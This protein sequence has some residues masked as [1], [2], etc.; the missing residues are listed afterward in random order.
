MFE[1][2]FLRMLVLLNGIIP[3]IILLADAN[4]GKLGANP[5]NIALHTTGILSLVFLFTSLVI[6]PLKWMTQWGGWLAMRRALGLYGFFY[7]VVH[8]IIYVVW[9]RSLNL[10]STIEEITTRRFLQVGM[11]ALILMVPLAVTSTNGMIKRIGPANWKR[12]HMLSYLVCILGVV[13]YYMLVKSDVSQPLAFGGVLA[14]I[15]G[16]RLGRGY[17][18][19]QKKPAKKINSD[20]ITKSGKKRWQGTLKL[21]SIVQETTDV[22]T[23]RFINPA[24]GDLPFTY[25]AGQFISIH[26]QI[27]GKRVNRTYTLAS[28]PVTKDFFELTIK[29]EPM[30][31]ASTH[32]HDQLKPGDMVSFSGPA[33]SFVF[34][35]QKTPAVVFIAGGVGITP[36]MSMLRTLIHTNWPGTI[37]F[38]FATKTEADIIFKNELEYLRNSYPQLKL[39]ITL[40]RE[41]TTSAWRGS[42][43]RLTAEI[44]QQLIPDI[45]KLPAYICGPNDMMDAA[46]NMLLESG[47]PQ[48]NIFTEA[49]SGA[50]SPSSSTSI[51]EE[52]LLDQATIQFLPSNQTL[53]V[54]NDYT[55]LELAESADI[56]IPY[57]CRS[58]ICGQCKVRLT[59][60]KVSMACQDA[61]TPDEKRHGYILACQAKPLS[62]L[63]V[64][65]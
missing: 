60:G 23:F 64:K 7:A 22:R 3:L 10:I 5:V 49:F 8:L 6:T 48:K 34:A 2:K 62:S 45:A 24:G 56:E 36:V 59:K 53:P 16:T 12:I 14:V 30:G 46:C 43:S 26:L 37:H 27:M 44:M 28:S 15:L 51:I 55:V 21:A 9:D 57:E 17:F 50:K 54:E 40:T 47:V 1:P 39:F 42:R 11:V 61:L 58:G 4:D 20:N 18:E 52:P 35:D 29:R 65:I 63:E 13:H 32:I 19:K 31:T 38:L 33:G 41:P 25:I